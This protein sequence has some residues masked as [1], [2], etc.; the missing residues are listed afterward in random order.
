VRERRQKVKLTFALD[1]GP[2][3]QVEVRLKVKRRGLFG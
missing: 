3:R 2:D 1:G